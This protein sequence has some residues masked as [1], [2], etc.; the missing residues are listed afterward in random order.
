MTKGMLD[1]DHIAPLMPPLMRWRFA[2]SAAPGTKRELTGKM[3][4]CSR[5]TPLLP[6][7]GNEAIRFCRYGER[8]RLTRSGLSPTAIDT[9]APYRG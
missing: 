4:V 9:L 5:R 1:R 6:R 8:N 7:D 3:R 2:W